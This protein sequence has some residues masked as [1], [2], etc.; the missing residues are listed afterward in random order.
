MKKKKQAKKHILISI[1]LLVA[2]LTALGTVAL[3]LYQ[4]AMRPNVTTPDRK[5]F[6]LYIPTGSD[7]QQVKD[8]LYANQLIQNPN[9]FEWLA[10]KKDYPNHVRP[11][12]FVIKN[13]ISNNQLVNML[14]GGLQTPIK[15]T[16]NNQ[17]TI[18]DLAGRISHQIEADSIEIYTLLN[19]T[20]SLKAWGYTKQT[21]PALFLPNTYEFY[22]NTDA[23]GFVQKMKAEHDRYW[24]EERRA[25]AE[26]IGMT[27][28]QVSTLASIVNKE[29]NKTDEMARIAGVYLNRLKSGWLL[30][31]DP[32]LVFAVGDF[33]LKRVLNVHKE[34]E[35]PYNTYKYPGLPQVPSASR[36]YRLLT[37][38][39]MQ[40]IIIITIFAQ[41][42]IFPAIITSPR[43]WQSTIATRKDIRDN[44]TR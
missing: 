36:H 41:K 35:S 2:V 33:S 34:V 29:T 11:G 4:R 21:I 32:T 17:R 31:A 44:S 20:D 19:N 7:F 40:S 42:K 43:H 5:D 15:V 30:Q 38:S 13:G 23:Y 16:F 9:S 27:P 22:W 12:H 6:S 26:A 1:I 14:R 25:K 8:S 3:C 39:S 10:E 18:A 28:I 37:P 24:N